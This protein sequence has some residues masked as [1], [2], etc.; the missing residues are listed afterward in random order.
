MKRFLILTLALCLALSGCA[1]LPAVRPEAAE[2]P[3]APEP[4]PLSAEEFPRVDG[5]VAAIPLMQAML[6]N[7]TGMDPTQAEYAVSPSYETGRTL[8]EKQQTDLLLVYNIEDLDGGDWEVRPL[9][10]DGLVFAVGEENP[11]SA[12]TSAQLQQIYTGQ[13][14]N[15]R[16]LGGE[17]RTI[18]PLQQESGSDSQYL[19]RT[20]ILDGQEPMDAPV[21]PYREPY[22]GY[23]F[24]SLVLFRGE[25]DQLSFTTLSY[26]NRL[27]TGS[28]PK[29]LAVDNVAP[30]QQT[31]ATQTYPL[32]APIY[33]VI[34][35]DEAADS[36]ARQLRDWLLTDSGAQFLTDAG[37]IPCTDS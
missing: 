11:V 36:P 8:L 13:L 5:S 10:L 31:I 9:C 14:Q 7:L 20:L 27:Y 21:E 18:Q 2:A 26:L 12:V 34:R 25:A 3:R 33:V 6:V 23:L 1:R 24:S 30:T 19:L 4:F 15:W 22:D 35:S 16:D 29:L 17:D 37:Y 32:T 28:Q